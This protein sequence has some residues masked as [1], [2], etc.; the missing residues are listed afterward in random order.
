VSLALLAAWLA[1]AQRTV[2]LWGPGRRAPWTPER[3]GMATLLAICVVFGVH[4]F[5]DWTWFVPGNAILALLCAGW[6]AGRG[7]TTEPIERREPAG[8]TLRQPWRLGLA[9]GAAAIAL[10]AAWTS[11]QPQRAVAKGSDA[12]AA[13]EAGNY[14]QARSEIADA[15]RIDPLSVELLY[16]RSAIA[17]AAGDVA[18]ARRAL[19]DS[20]RKQPANAQTWLNLAQFEL[21][22][23]RKPQALSAIGSALYLDPRSPAAISVYLQA[24][25]Q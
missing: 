12:L 6:V 8:V 15:E 21:D 13:A 17:S 14:P 24:S 11:W 25:R 16:Q 7:P 2:G 9:A 23:G 4:S 20:V 22:Q 1:A 19:E 18:G 3:V 10:L 5:V